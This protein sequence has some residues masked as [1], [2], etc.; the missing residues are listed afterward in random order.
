MGHFIR[1][2]KSSTLFCQFSIPYHKKTPET[3]NV[4][5]KTISDGDLNE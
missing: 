4:F 1:T 2:R 5:K 3:N